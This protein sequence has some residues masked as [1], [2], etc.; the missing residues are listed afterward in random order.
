MWQNLTKQHNLHTIKRRFSTLLGI[1]GYFDYH[2]ILNNIAYR[3]SHIL[4]EALQISHNT[5]HIHNTSS[6]AIGCQ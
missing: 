4:Q 3:G 6:K 5:A 1:V 2:V